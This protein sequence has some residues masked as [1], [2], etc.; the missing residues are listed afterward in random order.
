M[1]QVDGISKVKNLTIIS[2]NV[3][4][5]QT[6]IGDLTH[7]YIIPQN[8]D[9]VATVET[10]L[11]NN[12]PDNFGHIDG[13]S[14]WYRRDRMHGTFGGIAV[15]FRKGLQF[16]QIEPNLPDHLELSFFDYG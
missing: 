4:G 2:S 6:N 14:K 9:V 10:F 5:F 3:R 16:Q 1:A 12:I 11:N 13:Y 8:A 7:S 15:C